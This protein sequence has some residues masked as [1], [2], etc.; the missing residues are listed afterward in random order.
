[1]ETRVSTVEKMRIRQMKSIQNPL[2]HRKG[3]MKSLAGKSQ[4]VQELCILLK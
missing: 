1:M 4:K 3:K 2:G